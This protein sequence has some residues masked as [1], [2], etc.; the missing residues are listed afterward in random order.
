MVVATALCADQ[1]STAAPSVRSQVADPGRAANAMNVGDLAGRL[2]RR[3]SRSLRE[4]VPTAVP[5]QARRR[6]RVSTVA[7]ATPADQALG[8]VPHPF[9]PFQFR[10]PPPNAA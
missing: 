8:V 2:V 9:S 7:P 4:A 1:V 10:L 5:C 3:L 6:E